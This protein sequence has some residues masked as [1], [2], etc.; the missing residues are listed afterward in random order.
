M[1]IV[2]FSANTLPIKINQMKTKQFD[3]AK[4]LAL[5]YEA[6][7]YRETMRAPFVSDGYVC[8]TETHRLILLKPEI[9]T[10]DYNSV[11][12]PH[13]KKVLKPH[14]IDITLTLEQ[15][16]FL[17][18]QYGNGTPSGTET[19]AGTITTN[20]KHHLVTVK[21]NFL[22]NPQFNSAGSSTDIPCFTLIAHMD[23]R[24]P[25]LVVT[26][27]GD[28]AIQIY[29]TDSPMMVK[30]KKFMAMYF[31]VD[32]KMRMLTVDELKLIMGFPEDY[33][34]VGTQADKKKFLGNAV[35]VTV[36]RKWCEALC[37]ELHRFKSRNK[38]KSAA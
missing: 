25:C 5:F 27:S 9:C 13:V 2:S 17:D 28:I 8:A 23:K 6:D 21:R 34:L 4:L 37:A 32:I 14:N 38:S 12:T 22:M 36:A 35:E 10:G 15:L 24:P 31:I 19:A 3:E 16:T 33:V 20:P 11:K 26:E 7:N 1:K 18:M 30:I 29:E